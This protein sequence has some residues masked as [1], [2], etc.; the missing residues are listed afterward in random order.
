MEAVRDMAAKLQRSRDVKAAEL[1]RKY[2]SQHN[3]KSMREV[4]SWAKTKSQS[5]TVTVIAFVK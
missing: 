5:R 4:Q 3:D 1:D 2:T